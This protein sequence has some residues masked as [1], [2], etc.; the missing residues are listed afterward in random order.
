MQ[1]RKQTGAGSLSVK[2]KNG[3]S[4][5]SQVPV[6]ENLDGPFLPTTAADMSSLRSALHIGHDTSSNDSLPDSVLKH[7]VQI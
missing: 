6:K 1:E 4:V 5:E 7:F 2:G 3:N